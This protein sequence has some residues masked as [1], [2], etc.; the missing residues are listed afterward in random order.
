MRSSSAQL[1]S[2]RVTPR[3]SSYAAASTCLRRSWRSETAWDVG[4]KGSY[5]VVPSLTETAATGTPFTSSTSQS[6]AG[7]VVFYDQSRNR[8]RAWCSMEVCGNREKA[9]SFRVRHH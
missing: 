8:S 2:R 7:K 9:R 6:P 4:L 3:R 1:R 5:T